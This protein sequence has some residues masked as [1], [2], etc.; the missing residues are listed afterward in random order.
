MRLSILFEARDLGLEKT[1][2][3]YL[4]GNF[5]AYRFKRPKDFVP[6]MPG[7]GGKLSQAVRY[8]AQEMN[9]ERW[10]ALEQAFLNRAITYAGKPSDYMRPRMSLFTYLN[11][12]KEPWLEG[13]AMAQ[14]FLD[15]PLIKKAIGGERGT[16]YNRYMSALSPMMIKY[17]INKKINKP[18]LV[19]SFQ[20][21][22]AK[23]AEQ[24][25]E[26]YRI[27][28]AF[29][30]WKQNYEA[31]LPEWERKQEEAKRKALGSE[32]EFH[33][34]DTFERSANTPPWM[35]DQSA[36]QPPKDKWG[37]I[38]SYEPYKYYWGL[39]RRHGKQGVDLMRKYADMFT[40]APGPQQQ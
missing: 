14:K 10:P 4:Q 31:W 24:E 20:E 2:E 27:A 37:S 8:H 6:T 16:T 34:D 25:A 19:Q 35:L 11:N 13:E 7:M 17:L 21:L 22:L 9:G 18:E 40:N 30:I 5:G 3:P 36:P 38:H 39:V 15:S 12:I 23:D 32:G 28:K 33:V 26:H 29:P 1:L